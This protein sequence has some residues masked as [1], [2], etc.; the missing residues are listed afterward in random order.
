MTPSPLDI[1]VVDLIGRPGT[2]RRVHLE[3]PAPAGF[4]SDVMAVPE[5]EPVDVDLSLESVVDGIYVAGSATAHIA[6]EC[7]RCLD[8]VEDDLMVRLDELFMFPEKLEAQEKAALREASASGHGTDDADEGGADLSVVI[9]DEVHLMPLLR[10]AFALAVPYRPLCR[11]DCLGLCSQ[12]G[13]RLDDDPKHHHDVI[14]TRWAALSA[15]LGDG[16]AAESDS[17][18]SHRSASQGSL[19]Y[20]SPSQPQSSV[21]EPEGDR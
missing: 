12:C 6:G 7:S 15:L 10:D 13:V 11:Q 14:D 4:G 8:P 17:S 5:G 3:V 16:D 21:S 9:D 19:S 2:Q 20:G 18:D 1:E